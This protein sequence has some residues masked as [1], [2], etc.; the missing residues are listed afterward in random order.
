M[1][2]TKSGLNVKLLRRIQRHI[3][4]RPSRFMM[5]WYYSKGKPG[6]RGGSWSDQPKRYPPCGTVACI[7][8]WANILT[9]A[10]TTQ[11]IQD[12][13][14]AARKLGLP[15]IPFGIYPLFGV[16]LWSTDFATR[17]RAATTPKERVKIASEVIDDLIARS[18][19]EP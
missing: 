3:F 7:A 19:G 2:S 15:D 17:Y 5:A 6:A 12:S 16:H 18:V 14:R 11:E 1:N 9:G 13:T 8:G 4:V 10:K